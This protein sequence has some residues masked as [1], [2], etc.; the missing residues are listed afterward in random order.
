MSPINFTESVVAYHR[1][2]ATGDPSAALGHARAA[3]TW[4][5][6]DGEAARWHAVV[7]DLTRIVHPTRGQRFLAWLGVARG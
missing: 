5:P 2:V 1:A 6:C 7:V 3:M 4:A